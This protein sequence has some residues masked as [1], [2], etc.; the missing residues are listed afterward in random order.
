[1][2]ADDMNIHQSTDFSAAPS[3]VGYLFQCRYALLESLNRLRNERQFSVSIETIDDVVFATEGQPPDLLQ[4]KHHLNAAANLTDASPELWKTLRVWCEEIAQGQIPEHAILFLVTTAT[5]SEGTAAYYLRGGERLRDVPTALERLTVTVQSSTNQSLTDAFNAFKNLDA[6]QKLAFLSA[7][8]VLDGVPNINDMD[9]SLRKAVYFAAPQKHL[10]S[11]LQRLE[12]WWFQRSVKQ[13]TDANRLPILSEELADET[14]RIR[15]QFKDDALPID[16]DIITALVDESGYQDRVFVE[17]LKLIL[18]GNPRI[19]QAIRDYYRAFEHRSR[20][21][22]EDL[23]LVGDL[24]RYEDRLLEEWNIRFHQMRDDAGDAATED[25]KRAAA[26]ALYKWIETGAH[27]RI[28]ANVSEPSI[29]RGTY[30]ILSDCGRVGW[31]HDFAE[32][33]KHLLEAEG[34]E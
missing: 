25:A 31:H 7:V 6:A 28:R 5:A 23:L 21:M 8:Y 3:L 20:W 10:A 22:R 11:Y 17:Q 30:Q 29:A 12:G 33:I 16:D 14:A 2:A 18:I 15:E 27:A 26:I 13:L 1:M 4:T 24:E 34:A 19:A 9:A 32:R